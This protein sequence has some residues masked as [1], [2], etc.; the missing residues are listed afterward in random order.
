MLLSLAPLHIAYL[1]PGRK[2]LKACMQ[3]VEVKLSNFC[4]CFRTFFFF[5]FLLGSRFENL[6]LVESYWVWHCP[7]RCLLSHAISNGHHKRRI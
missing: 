6:E 3:G 4:V 2:G 7:S 5:S 1:T